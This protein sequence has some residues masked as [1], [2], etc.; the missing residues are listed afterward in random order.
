[1]K[2]QK[3][4]N[5]LNKMVELNKEKD[6]WANSLPDELKYTFLENTYANAEGLQIDLLID[7]IF[8]DL[9][10]EIHCFLSEPFPQEIIGLKKVYNINSVKDYVDYLVNE[11]LIKENNGKKS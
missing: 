2:V 10:E 8:K 4:E 6:E 5:L 3:I 9:S 11:G 7:Y 1:M